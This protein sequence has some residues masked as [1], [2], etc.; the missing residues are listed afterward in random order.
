[1]LPVTELLSLSLSLS[2]SISRPT[3]DPPSS[4]PSLVV[5]RGP[6]R[7]HLVPPPPP[8][9]RKRYTPV[10]LNEDQVLNGD[11]LVRTEDLVFGNFPSFPT[12]VW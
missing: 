2:P 11:H 3:L 6:R 9:Q 4:P 7:L 10:V 1:M 12:S 5:P 8:S